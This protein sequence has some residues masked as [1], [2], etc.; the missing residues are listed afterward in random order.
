MTRLGECILDKRCVRFAGGVNPKLALRHDVPGRS[1][2]HRRDFAHLCSVAGRQDE[3]L[4]HSS[5]ACFCADT[6]ER[7]PP[8]ASCNIDSICLAENGAPS[9]VPCTS[10]KPPLPVITM[11]ISV[12]QPESST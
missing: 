12:S 9:A 3:A 11:F 5:R 10:T 4:S 2:Q 1:N 6:N 7:M 8:L